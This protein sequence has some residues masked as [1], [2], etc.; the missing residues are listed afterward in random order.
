MKNNSVRLF[1]LLGV[2]AVAACGDDDPTGLTGD[3]S[4][5]EA[6]DLAGLIFQLGFLNSLTLGIPQAVDGPARV[7]ETSTVSLETTSSCPL[8]G[9]VALDATIV[10]TYDTE[11]FDSSTD[12]SV[13]QTPNGCVVQSA[14][15]R[16]FTL[17]GS[18]S[19][20]FAFLANSNDQGTDISWLGSMTGGLAWE[21]EGRSGTC[22]VAL[23]YSGQEAGSGAASFS[24][25]GTVCGS[26]IQTE[27]SIG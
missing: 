18:P 15:G 21:T 22:T 24:I 3:L 1:A 23:E 11:T 16:Q 27:F 19:I 8:G 2:F 13:V 25:G 4:Q 20:T 26:S 10:D 7:I 9:T 17:N 5:T 12:F 6:E 14:G